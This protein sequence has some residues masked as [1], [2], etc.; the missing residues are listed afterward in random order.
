[1]FLRAHGSDNGTSVAPAAAALFSLH[2]QF[3]LFILDLRIAI[4]HWRWGEQHGMAE[5]WRGWVGSFAAEDGSA[6]GGHLSLAHAVI[7]PRPPWSG[8]E[9][10][11]GLGSTLTDRELRMR[12]C[13]YFFFS[14]CV[15]FGEKEKQ[16]PGSCQWDF[17]QHHQPITQLS[18]GSPR[19]NLGQWIYRWSNFLLH[20]FCD[21]L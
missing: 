11:R 13:G 4:E 2:W 15:C 9:S 18:Y 6:R 21:A 10:F 12:G 3:P 16:P 17:R 1:M 8:G 20:S 7:N 5:K 14:S 19:F